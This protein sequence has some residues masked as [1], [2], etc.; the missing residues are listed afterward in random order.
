MSKNQKSISRVIRPGNDPRIYAAAKK[1]LERLIKERILFQEEKPCF[2]VYGQKQ[3]DHVQYGI[4]ACVSIAEYE[5]RSNQ[6]ARIDNSRQ[7][8]GPDQKYRY[9][10]CQHRPRLLCLSRARR[11]LIASWRKSFNRTRNTI[12]R[13]TMVSPTRSGS[14]VIRRGSKPSGRPF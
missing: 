7:R 11:P 2:Y 5:A 13:L 10:Q 14:S 9:G 8:A 4:V 12:S 1:A 3:G 6:K